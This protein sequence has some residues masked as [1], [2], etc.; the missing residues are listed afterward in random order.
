LLR[1][2]QYDFS[3]AILDWQPQ[4]RE[5]RTVVRCGHRGAQ[6]DGYV[7][8]TASEE[9]MCQVRWQVAGVP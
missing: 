3:A 8:E 2:E 6:M 5:Q 9:R 1:I 7:T 4:S